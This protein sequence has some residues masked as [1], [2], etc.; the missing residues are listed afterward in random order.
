MLA[1]R[2]RGGCLTAFL[3]W[4]MRRVHKASKGLFR[5]LRARGNGTIIWVVNDDVDFD[6]LTT[7]FGDT[8]DGVM[9]DYPTN[10]STWA[11]RH[12]DASGGRSS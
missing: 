8:L 3:I 1:Q 5:H 10:L 2:G 6:E 12:T 7:T 9:T 4:I 11:K